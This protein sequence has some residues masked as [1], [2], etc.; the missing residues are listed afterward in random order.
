MGL[1][2]D[3][4]EDTNPKIEQVLAIFFLRSNDK[5]FEKIAN[6]FENGV[7]KKLSHSPGRPDVN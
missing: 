5:L 3:H 1:I 2:A 4:A 6:C 7:A